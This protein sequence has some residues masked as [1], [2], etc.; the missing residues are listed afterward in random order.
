MK[1]FSDAK[2]VEDSVNQDRVGV[3][4]GSGIGGIGTFQDEVK[5][6]FPRR[7]YSKV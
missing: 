3:I 4:F 6:F 5:G 7:W 1:Q 2:L